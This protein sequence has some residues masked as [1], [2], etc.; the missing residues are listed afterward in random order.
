MNKEQLCEAFCGELEVRKVPAGFAVRTGFSASDGDTIGFYITRHPIEQTLYRLEDSGLIVPM[1]EASGVN[2]DNG[3]R[4]DAFQRMLSEYNCHFDDDS[5]EINSEYV[6]EE[7]IPNEAMRFIALM[8][9]VRDLEMLNHETVKNAWS[10]DA[11]EALKKEFEGKATLEFHSMVSKTLPDFIVDAVIRPKVGP[12][13]AL[14]FATSD[15]K[16][17]ESV[18]LWMESR[19]AKANVKVA[20]LLEK[21]KPPQISGRPLRRAFNRLDATPS[22]RG[23]E[24]AAMARIGALAGNDYLN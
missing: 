21:E 22:F 1:L 5:F 20:L 24:S 16:V 7:E 18:M 4:A 19:L 2:L 12:P 23:D 3:V 13:V 9:R 6:T 14:Y 15:S 10:E 11:Q 8:L 17:D